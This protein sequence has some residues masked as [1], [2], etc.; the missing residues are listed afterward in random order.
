VESGWSVKSMHRL[1]MLSDAYRR[2]SRPTA[3]LLEADPENRLWG[4]MDRRRLEA[5]ELHDGLLALSGRLDERPGGPAEADPASPRRLIYVATSRGDRSDFGSVFDR[6]NPSLHVERR[7]VSTVAPQALYLMNHPWVLEQARALARRP[8]VAAEPDPAR[9]MARLYQV[10]Y[11]RPAAA[12][13]IE[14][15]RKLLAPEPAGADP[16]AAWD[17]YAQALL[18]TNEFLFVD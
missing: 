8:D 6:A 4:R 17:R 12:E 14:L 7:T 10:V 1:I 11:G 3:S 18:L 9:R 13:E 15:G 16:Q 5:E 2:S